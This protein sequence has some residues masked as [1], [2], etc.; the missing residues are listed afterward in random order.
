M[1]T[2][3][4]RSLFLA[5]PALAVAAAGVSSDEKPVPPLI[6]EM[7]GTW[8]VQEWMWPGPGAQAIVL[9]P[10]V[11]RRRLIGGKF[12]EEVM[13]GATGP[14]APFSR[15]AYF[16][17][18]A[19][20]EQYEYFS[21]DTRAPQMMNERSLAARGGSEGGGPLTLQGGT[22]VA[23]EW[24]RFGNT[25]FRYRIVI[26]PVVNDRQAVRL[27]LTPLTG[28]GPAPDHEEFLAFRYLYT[29]QR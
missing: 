1:K 5:L 20:D 2:I 13:T 14:S 8:D 27:Y 25:A 4:R 21:I 23:P 28:P 9:A 6:R 24:G 18:N 7:V 29:R 10:A 11:A 19:V 26:V 12:L 22:F 17:Y 3:A 15:I 16:D